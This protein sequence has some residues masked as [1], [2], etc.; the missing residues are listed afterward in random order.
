MYR[1]RIALQRVEDFF[2]VL[3]CLV[4]ITGGETPPVCLGCL[5]LRVPVVTGPS[6]SPR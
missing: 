3:P 6:H 1:V 5:P 2:V 4:A